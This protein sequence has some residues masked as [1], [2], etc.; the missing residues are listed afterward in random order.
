MY[1]CITYTEVDR[2]GINLLV[3]GSRKTSWFYDRLGPDPD[4]KDDSL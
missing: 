2:Y 1:E 4:G 3:S